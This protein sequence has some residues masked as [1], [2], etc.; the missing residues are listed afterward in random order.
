MELVTSIEEVQ[1]ILT[2]NTRV[3]I[4]FMAEWCPPCKA[5]APKIEKLA[6]T[7]TDIKFIKVDAQKIDGDFVSAQSVSS[8]PTIKFFKDGEAIETLTVIGP[9][10]AKVQEG[11]KKLI[12]H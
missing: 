8:M 12:L 10:F 6:E 7:D 5:L 2:T 3:V 9:N 11:V 1:K 4:D